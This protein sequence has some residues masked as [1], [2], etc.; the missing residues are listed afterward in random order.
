MTERT[1]RFLGVALVVVSVVVVGIVWLNRSLA[2]LPEDH[3]QVSPS[4]QFEDAADAVAYYRAQLRRTPRSAE[5]RVRLAQALIQLAEEDGRETELIPEATE[6]LAE[7]LE[8]DPDH[9]Y[10]QTIQASLYNKLHEFERARDLSRELLEAYPN[11]AYVH[12][13]LIDAL[14]ELGEYDEAVAASDRLQTL[15]P[16]LP[17]YSRASYLRE[18]HGD[19]DGAIAA[20]TLA[21]DAEPYGRGSRA[22]ALYQLGN[23]YLGQAKPDT[24]AFIFEGILEERPDFAPALT[25]LGHVALVG[26]DADEAVHL[27]EESRALR[28]MEATDEVL[29]EAYTAAGDRRKA[30]AAADRVLKALHAAREMGEIVDME[31]ADFLADRGE[32]LGRA[33]KMAKEQVARRPGHLHA[34]ETYAWTLYKTGKA[35]DAVPYIERAMRL[36]TGDAMVHYRAARIYQAAGRGGEAARHLQLALDGHLGVES[37]SAEAEARALHASMGPAPV[38]ATSAA[39]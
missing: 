10:G 15:R 38:Q 14:V 27:L 9:Y 4:A 37:P 30:E 5:V 11:H 32:D 23:L 17:A 20:M 34:N 12:G 13:T 7:A 25:G 6:R 26:G 8:I 24:A 31:E 22:W 18:L 35:R 29:V 3:G 39:R 33:L 36:D 21:A 2:P 1:S 16:G 19:A 28:P